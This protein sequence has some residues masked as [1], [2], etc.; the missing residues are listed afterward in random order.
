MMNIIKRMTS[1]TP[2]FFRKLRTLGLVLAIIGGGIM[3]SEVK[4]PLLINNVGEYL[5]LIG[6]IMS[7]MSQITVDDAKLKS[8]DHE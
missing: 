8:K 5:T 2:K 3:S 7:A 1:P 4:L 6:G